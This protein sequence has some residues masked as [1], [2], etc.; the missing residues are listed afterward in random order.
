[1][2]TPRV[3][4]RSV[5]IA[6]ATTGPNAINKAVWSAN[7]DPFGT[8]IGNSA[9]N[10][11]PQLVSGTATQI[12]AATFKQNHRFPGQV[13][14]GE[15]GKSDNWNRLYDPTGARY[16]TSDPIGLTAGLST[17]GYVG[18]NPANNIDP[19]G[20]ATSGQW[21]DCG[22]GCR[23]RIEDNH[24]GGGRHM[25]WECKG[26]SGTCGEFGTSSHGDDCSGAP[27]RVKDCARNNGF[28]PDKLLLLVPPDKDFCGQNCVKTIKAVKDALTGAVIFV[29]VCLIAIS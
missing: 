15:S 26:K 5:A 12:Q 20:L 27:N 2:G 11:N 1:L 22:G 13:F 9:P 24:R 8:S 7:T 17:Y 4:T 19:T 23:I 21:K 10:E 3:V 6:G 29:F 16:T 25:H 14:D 28:E 18:Q